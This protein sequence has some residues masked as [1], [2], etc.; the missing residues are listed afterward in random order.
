MIERQQ[1]IK[2]LV[3]GYR[4]SEGDTTDTII[5]RMADEVM[6]VIECAIVERD[7]YRPQPP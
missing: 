1:I 6:T 3:R 4:R 7:T 5:G 2:A